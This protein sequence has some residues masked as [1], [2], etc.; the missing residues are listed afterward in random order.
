MKDHNI[1]SFDYPFDI[2]LLKLYFDAQQFEGYTDKR[3]NQT[4]E[5]WRIARTEMFPYAIELCDIFNIKNG[6]PRF[7]VLEK[8]AILPMH[9]D[10]NTTC[11]LNIVLSDDLAPVKFEDKSYTYRSCILNTTKMHGV[12]NG[13]SS[14]KLFKISVFDQSFEEMCKNVEKVLS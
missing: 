7:Y 3:Y 11:S 4:L 5:T 2:E 13:N 8:N 9:T 6:N 10:L 14:R 12:D 1:Y